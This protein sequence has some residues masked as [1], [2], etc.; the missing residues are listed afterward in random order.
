MTHNIKPNS[1]LHLVLFSV[2]GVDPEVL[3]ERKILLL[4]GS[5]MFLTCA[6]LASPPPCL[7]S[8]WYWKKGFVDSDFIVSL[9]FLGTGKIIPSLPFDIF[10][11]VNYSQINPNLCW[12]SQ[13]LLIARLLL[14]PICPVAPSTSPS[15]CH[16]L[17]LM[18]WWVWYA[19][20][21]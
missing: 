16:L 8:H 17:Q 10:L 21:L 19:P 12:H 20:L 3:T 2:H 6:L 5:H 13:P 9:A 15:S 14:S 4:G 18:C 7:C 1:S 11:I